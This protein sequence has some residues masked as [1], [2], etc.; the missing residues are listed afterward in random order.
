M[1]GVDQAR[2]YVAKRLEFYLFSEGY[3][4]HVNQMPLGQ[5]VIGWENKFNEG[6]SISTKTLIKGLA[7]TDTYGPLI[8]GFFAH[9]KV[10]FENPGIYLNDLR[11]F[12]PDNELFIDYNTERDKT[13]EIEKS[14]T[15]S[16]HSISNEIKEDLEFMDEL[17]NTSS[18]SSTSSTKG[19]KST[20]KR[21]RNNKIEED[22]LMEDQSEN[23]K[24]REW[25]NKD[26]E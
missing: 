26:I 5:E 12:H 25:M 8:R 15:S 21:K 20:K 22:K 6:R 16:I 2:S 9:V 14:E 1:N 10:V 11:C 24:I 19:T 7:L 18:T 4:W 17:D 13:H 3:V 23:N